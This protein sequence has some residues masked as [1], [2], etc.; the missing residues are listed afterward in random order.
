MNAQQQENQNLNAVTNQGYE[1]AS[2]LQIRLNTTPVKD[3][4]EA[5]LR[6]ERLVQGTD[7]NGQPVAELKQVGESK[8]NQ[9]GIQTIMSMIEAIFNPQV[10]QG[11]FDESFLQ[12]YL[13]RIRMALATEL[14]TNLHRYE[15]RIEEYNGIIAM[16]MSF[17]EPYMSRL[18]NNK[19]R[20]SYAQTLKS[21]ETNNSSVR[22]GGRLNGL[23]GQ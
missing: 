5:Y 13:F 14:M 11:N 12:D 18:L 23:F 20:E 16:L 21:I 19:E 15:I 6:G 9:L 22:G 7:V 1:A 10:V 4:I 8:A 17:I 2:A 3:Q